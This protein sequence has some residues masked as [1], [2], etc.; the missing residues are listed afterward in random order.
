M[1]SRIR[2]T[3]SQKYELADRL[4][5]AENK[6]VSKRLLAISLRH[7][8]YKIAD[9]AKIQDVSER[10]VR[11]WIRLF[12]EGGFDKLTQLRYD[13]DRH[14]RLQ[15]YL[16]HIR[17]WKHAHPQ[18][19]LLELQQYLKEEHGLEVEYSWLYRWLRKRG[20]WG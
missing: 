1:K 11:S 8:G 18:G 17:R 16:G 19:S 14:S 15:P 2:L 5:L 6:K 20:L 4:R 13:G 9:I 10:T 12:Q 7:Y 3:L